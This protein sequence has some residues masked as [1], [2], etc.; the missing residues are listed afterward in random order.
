VRF[1]LALFVAAASGFVALSYEILWYR[2]Y[3]FV[4]QG[5]PVAFGA[6]LGFYLI[7][8]AIGS[9]R[10]RVYFDGQG[11][12]SR[13]QERAL[14]RFLFLANAVAYLAA[15][16]MGFCVTVAPWPVSLAVVVVAT[17]LTGAI[18][19]LVSH[20]AILPDDRAGAYL[21]YLYVANILGSCAG[22]LV[23]GFVAMDHFTTREVAVGLAWL[24]FLVALVVILD[25]EQGTRRALGALVVVAGA[26]A[27]V[28]VS[29]AAFDQLYERLLYRTTFR[30]DVHFAESVENRSGLIHVTTDGRVFG[31]G[32]Y[33][34]AFNTSIENDR[35]GIIRAY[36]VTA[37]HPPKHLLMIGLSSGSWA[38]VLAASPSLESF[39]IVEIN[40][41][42]LSLIAQHPEVS[43]ILH[44]PKVTIVI[45]D[46]RRW[47]ESH[48]TSTFDT[49]VMNTTWHWRAHATNLL[50]REFFDLV[51]RHLEPHG[52]FYFN[53]TSSHDACA[54]ALASFPQA[55][56]VLNFLGGSDAPLHIDRDVW[57]DVLA[58]YRID[59][60]PVVS[61]EGEDGDE[62][63]RLVYFLE[64]GGGRANVEEESSLVLTC[65][66]GEVIT[67]DNMLPEWRQLMHWEKP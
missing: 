23:T 63:E 35:N 27:S 41:G 11:A 49:I 44:D 61:D 29:H 51:K 2:L 8:I 22:S 39:T 38:K 20:L 67:D 30:P 32:V 3:A 59:G 64:A 10:S 5:A 7:G 1:G 25:T 17:A 42:Y 58:K 56:R 26:T 33:D 45:D 24:G 60:A 12:G 28:M 65:K 34:G 31:G 53:T 57:R 54:T 47:L 18:L 4:T 55:I 66:D 9:Y 21:S 6:L 43:G 16:A 52:L 37:L 15:P 19:P 40:P 50:S 62:K 13:E 14:G 36:A 46:G 48:P